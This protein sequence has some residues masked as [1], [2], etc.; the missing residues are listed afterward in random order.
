MCSWSYQQKQNTSQ[1]VGSTNILPIRRL[2]LSNLYVWYNFKTKPFTES[3]GYP[4]TYFQK[5][6]NFSHACREI[7]DTATPGCGLIYITYPYR[8]R[9]NKVYQVVYFHI[10]S[11]CNI[12]NYSA[13]FLHICF[14]EVLIVSMTE[15]VLKLDFQVFIP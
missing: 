9:E 4:I 5:I 3:F 10:L 14:I 6:S 15:V 13:Q 1:E 12:N 11:S 7:A 8:N 2:C